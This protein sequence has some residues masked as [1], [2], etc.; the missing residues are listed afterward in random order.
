MKA[1]CSAHLAAEQNL[2]KIRRKVFYKERKK[3]SDESKL[4]CTRAHERFGVI[5]T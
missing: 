5:K 1:K 2:E 3:E 4:P